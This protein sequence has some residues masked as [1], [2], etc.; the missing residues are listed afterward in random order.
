MVVSERDLVG[1]SPPDLVTDVPETPKDAPKK[2]TAKR[3]PSRGSKAAQL[4][5]IRPALTSGFVMVGGGMSIALPLTGKTLIYQAEDLTDSL[6]AWGKTSPR[7]AKILLT[8]GSTGGAFGFLAAAAPLAI[9]AMAEMGTLSPD[10]AR[11][12]LPEELH[13]FIPVPRERTWE[14]DVGV[15]PN[16]GEGQPV[17]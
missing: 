2:S 7:I 10:K 16:G 11:N 6:I 3:A 1:G 9:A 12:F 4:D 13:E 5:A 15:T 17:L 14:Q 8:A